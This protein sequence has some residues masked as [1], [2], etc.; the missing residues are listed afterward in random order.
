M[1]LA[2]NPE[3]LRGYI[4]AL[5]G[6]MVEHPARFRFE[7]PLSEAR[8]II[9][10]INKLNLRCEKVGERQDSDINGRACSI[11]TIELRRQ[12]PQTDSYSVERNLMAA[13]I[14]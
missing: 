4:E 1:A 5:G 3:A 14:R 12:Q 8:R 11:A 13:I 7:I 9:P 6:S 10:E 2:D